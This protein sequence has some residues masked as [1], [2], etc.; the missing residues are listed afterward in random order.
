M[1]G[2]K[3][4]DFVVFYEGKIVKNVE[5]GVVYFLDSSVA[6]INSLKIINE[7]KGI[8]V[9]RSLL[10][11]F[12]EHT[13]RKESTVAELIQF[14]GLA[15]TLRIELHDEPYIDIMMEGPRGIIKNI[16]VNVTD[17][18]LSMIQRDGNN[19]LKG[20]KSHKEESSV[21]QTPISLNSTSKKHQRGYIKILVP[22]KTYIEIDGILGDIYIPDLE[23]SVRL[24]CNQK[25]F[26]RISSAKNVHAVL[27]KAAHLYIERLEGVGTFELEDSSFLDIKDGKIYD[28]NILYNS[29]ASSKIYAEIQTANIEVN[30]RGE[31][32]INGFRIHSN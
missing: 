22:S 10:D 30:T 16:D 13:V 29:S 27:K 14:S 2:V 18:T 4:K 8:I 5:D 21:P 23:G 25:Q 3:V 17:G 26:V 32:R 31:L 1:N 9:I 28:F 24:K 7:G 11:V 6:D 20:I 15:T 19:W 12:N